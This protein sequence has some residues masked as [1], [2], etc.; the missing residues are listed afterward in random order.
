MVQECLIHMSKVHNTGRTLDYNMTK[1]DG[2][3]ASLISDHVDT[4]VICQLNPG[5]R[6]RAQQL[7]QLTCE[8]L[9]F[10]KT[11]IIK[12]VNSSISH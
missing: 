5:I 4:C 3:L 8:Y 1:S 7:G 12:N 6:V 10:L 11:W 2:M 9:F